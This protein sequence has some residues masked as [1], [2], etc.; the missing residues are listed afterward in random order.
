M[1]NGID[2]HKKIIQSGEH[3]CPES[4]DIKSRFLLFAINH[5]RACKM[6]Q[7]DDRFTS[8]LLKICLCLVDP[9]LVDPD[10]TREETMCGLC[11]HALILACSVRDP[12]EELLR[13]VEEMA[14]FIVETHIGKIKWGINDMLSHGRNP[15]KD[16]SALLDIIE[17]IEA[18]SVREVADEFTGMNDHPCPSCH[19]MVI[20]GDKSTGSVDSLVSHKKGEAV[21][22]ELFCGGCFGQFLLRRNGEWLK[23]V[24]FDS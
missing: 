21:F 18:K 10:S 23:M 15:A 2:V 6:H 12:D 14:V 1:G 22:I 16:L 19:K 11:E 13:W 3:P 4:V 7:H 8:T 20:D 5:D 24:D 9:F 17:A